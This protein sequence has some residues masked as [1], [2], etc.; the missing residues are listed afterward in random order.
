MVMES[1]SMMV[2]DDG[3]GSDD[4]EAL[5]I[6]L[7]GMESRINLTPETKIVVLAAFCFMKRRVLPGGSI[8]RVYK[9]PREGRRRDDDRGPNGPGWHA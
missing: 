1:E 3:G 8:F 4:E 9:T 5:E 7:S 2:G 6:P